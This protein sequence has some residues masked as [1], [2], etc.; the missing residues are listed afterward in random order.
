MIVARQTPNE[1]IVIHLFAADSILQGL[2]EDPP[3]PLVPEATPDH[4]IC[5][6]ICSCACMHKYYVCARAHRG[7]CITSSVY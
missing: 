4:K 6:Y 2:N 1:Q 5:I 7:W 3:I